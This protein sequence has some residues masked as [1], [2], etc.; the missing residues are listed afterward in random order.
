MGDYYKCPR[1]GN[2]DI[3]KLGYLNGKIYCRAC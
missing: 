3:R 2:S 1:C